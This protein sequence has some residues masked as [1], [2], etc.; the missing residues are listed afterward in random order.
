MAKK[1][2]KRSQKKAQKIADKITP[3]FAVIEMLTDEDIDYLKDTARLI[4]EEISKRQSVMGVLIDYDKAE[5]ANAMGEQA[6][7]R[8]TGLIL[9][10]A[11]MR[12]KPEIIREYRKKATASANI[13]KMFG[14]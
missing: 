5:T 10:W 14:L 3:I 13:E 7:D 6:L 9:I 12:R 4:T 8:V 1:E 11:A 2:V